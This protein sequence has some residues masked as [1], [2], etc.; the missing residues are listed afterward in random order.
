MGRQWKREP[1]KDKSALRKPRSNNGQSYH[2]AGKEKRKTE[3]QKL[4]LHPHVTIRNN[5]TQVINDEER[6]AIF[7]DHW[8]HGDLM[9]QQPFIVEKVKM[10][11][12]GNRHSVTQKN[13]LNG[14]IVCK[15]M[16]LNTL[17]IS[18]KTVHTAFQKTD[19]NWIVGKDMRKGGNRKL[20]D[21]VKEEMSCKK[22]SNYGKSLS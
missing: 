2:C 4:K 13:S 5:C 21:E 14:R 17:S 20:S 19:E 6:N 8:Q 7:S 9:K 22:F 10:Y 16:F 11:G 12:E 15:T 3:H 18:E 1:L